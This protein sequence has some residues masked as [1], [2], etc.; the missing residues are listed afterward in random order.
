LNKHEAY[1]LIINQNK[2]I[3][4][5]FL[6]IMR[7]VNLEDVPVVGEMLFD[8][9]VRNKAD[10]VSF[11]SVFDGSY[12]ADM[13][14]AIKAVKDRRRSADVFDKQKKATIELY[15]KAHEL[16]ELVRLFGEYVKMAEENLQTRFEHYHIKEAGQELRLK[17]IE[18]ALEHCE[19]II[20]K[21][22]TDDSVALAAV[23]FD[24]GK[25]GDF[26]ALVQDINDRNRS[27][28]ELLNERQDVREAEEE[29]FRQMYVFIDRIAS[30]GK[31]MYTYKKKQ[32]YDD[33]SVNKILANINHGRKKQIDD[34]SGNG[35]EVA[36]YDVM[37]GRVVDKLSDVPIEGVV[38][39]LEGT[40]VMTDT[41][42]DGE[43][44]M[45]ELASGVFSVLFTKNGYE[46]MVQHNV[47]IGTANMVDL[48]VEMVESGAVESV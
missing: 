35:E 46:D 42:S 30:V 7:R 13:N 9:F 3:C 36:V 2:I 1:F 47:E 41:D 33:F 21:V 8:A 40:N 45:D 5:K 34:G 44:Y 14:D 29:A 24:A 15:Q 31:A 18:G 37:I 28:Q 12:E 23:G 17:N 19:I 10:F 20:D 11:S 22:N 48:Q 4:S 43:F 26:V 38:V 27:Q 32:K 6:E 25:L 16:Q 39:K